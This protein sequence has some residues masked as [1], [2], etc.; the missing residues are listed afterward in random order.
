MISGLEEPMP[1]SLPVFPESRA[2]A[3][4]SGILRA[5]TVASLTV[6]TLAGD[7]RPCLCQSVLSNGPYSEPLLI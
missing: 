1:G 7:R 3:Q 6:S 5:V 4:A 2:W